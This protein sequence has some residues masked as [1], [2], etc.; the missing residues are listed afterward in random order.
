M[1][2]GGETIFEKQQRVQSTKLFVMMDSSSQHEVPPPGTSSDTATTTTTSTCEF[3]PPLSVSCM[4]AS[5]LPGPDSCTSTTSTTQ[6]SSSHVIRSHRSDFSK[7]KQKKQ[8]EQLACPVSM[9]QPK[10]S[11]RSTCC[12]RPSSDTLTSSSAMLRPPSKQ[13]RSER[14]KLLV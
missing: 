3:V 1:S 9:P 4:S 13:K 5:A 2:R 12:K 6:C 7:G 11:G 14:E 8:Q 10:R